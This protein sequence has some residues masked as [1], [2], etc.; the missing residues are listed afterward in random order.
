MA[1]K[2][3]I[4]ICTV[5]F[6]LAIWQ[7][8][9]N[10]AKFKTEVFWWT[11]RHCCIETPDVKLKNRPFAQIFQLYGISTLLINRLTDGIAQHL[12]LASK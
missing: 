10:I 8:L 11:Q 12:L 3:Q 5:L 7:I 6:N 4:P 1:C 2:M 9:P